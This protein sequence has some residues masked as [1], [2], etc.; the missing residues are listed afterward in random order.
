MD[1]LYIERCRQKLIAAPIKTVQTIRYT[2]QVGIRRDAWSGI[3]RRI[4]ALRIGC[5]TFDV[6]PEIIMNL[7]IHEY[8]EG[9]LTNTFEVDLLEE[10]GGGFIFE[11]WKFPDRDM[12]HTYKLNGDDRR[13]DCKKTGQRIEGDKKIFKFKAEFF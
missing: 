11:T 6:V 12:T 7:I 4:S 3:L 13:L 10:V 8:L 2:L 9:K 1:Y 5:L